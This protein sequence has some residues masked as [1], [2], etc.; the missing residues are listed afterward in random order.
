MVSDKFRRELERE[1]KAWQEEGLL[2]PEQWMHLR[3][4]YNLDRLEAQAANRFTLILMAL[5]AVLVG[6]GVMTYVAAN[7]EEIPKLVR[8]VGLFGS[9][10]GV[11]FAGFGL[12]RS[13]DSLKQKLG[14]GLLLLGGMLIGANMALMAQMF[15]IT[16]PLHPLLIVW[17][18]AV[19]LMA[20]SL[21]HT[22][23]AILSVGLMGVGGFWG[24]GES[25]WWWSSFSANPQ[26][27]PYSVAIANLP[28]LAGLLFI[29]LAYRCRSIV[30]FTMTIAVILSS[31][32]SMWMDIQSYGGQFLKVLLL[33]LPTMLLWSYDDSL[34][35]DLAAMLSRGRS[36]TSNIREPLFQPIARIFSVLN[37]GALLYLCSFQSSFLIAQTYERD[38]ASNPLWL[39]T[40]PG[41]FALLLLAVVQWVHLVR[42]Q[43]RRLNSSIAIGGMAFVFAIA[44]LTSPVGEVDH[45]MVTFTVNALLAILGIGC[46]R[47]SLESQ[48]R[49]Q[50]WYGIGLI[51]LQVF[52][53]VLE[54]DTDL[55]LK[56]L[57]FVLCG[58]AISVA[59][60]WFEKSVRRSAGAVS[61]HD[62]GGPE[63]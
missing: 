7:W 10:V 39:F 34:W 56:A 32:I 55:L 37:F 25:S 61:Q 52:S 19:V 20:Y 57:M 46:I 16:G 28:F 17:S 5:G 51:V 36:Q 18:L 48:S 35:R 8:S 58:V 43:R 50:F 24:W 29:P 15:H 45:P 62:S 6:L 4:R 44:A 49:S 22:G 53:R 27:T 12:R 41:L 26:I 47:E 3:D 60:V 30:V 59:G 9:F 40:L 42:S 13:P 14:D 31:F 21:G 11:S 38:G 23:L 63:S 54:Y 1:G 33:V 2:Q